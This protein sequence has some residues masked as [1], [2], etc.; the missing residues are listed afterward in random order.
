M[1]RS[2]TAC[3]V[4]R[5]GQFS[6]NRVLS[7]SSDSSRVLRALR[8]PPSLFTTLLVFFAS[9]RPLSADEKLRAVQGFYSIDGIASNQLLSS[10][11][12]RAFT[13]GMSPRAPGFEASA[14]S[15][16]VLTSS[17]LSATTRVMAHTHLA[18]RYGIFETEGFSARVN[19][20]WTASRSIYRATA[21][22]MGGETSSLVSRT[23]SPIVPGTSYT[24]S[25]LLYSIIIEKY[26]T[27]DSQKIGVDS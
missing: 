21:F 25:R 22:G 27:V 6:L 18:T 7:W 1:G 8:N 23:P 5:P 10:N 14:L 26:R 3:H 2:P 12:K 20:S 17:F 19:Y 16:T 24:M 11:F 4:R 15:K 13:S 9:R